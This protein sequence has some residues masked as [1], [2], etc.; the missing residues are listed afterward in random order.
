MDF[1]GNK[2]DAKIMTG[3]KCTYLRDKMNLKSYFRKTDYTSF[4]QRA[5]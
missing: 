2:R 1:I 5:L 3:I 4:H